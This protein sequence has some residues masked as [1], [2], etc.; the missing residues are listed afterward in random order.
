MKKSVFNI[1]TENFSRGEGSTITQ[2]FFKDMNTKWDFSDLDYNNPNDAPNLGLTVMG[3][4]LSTVIDC[5]V[6]KHA[7]DLTELSLEKLGFT[8]LAHHYFELTE[9]I[10]K[11]AMVFGRSREKVNG[12]YVVAAVFRGTSS[13]ADVISDIKAEP[14]G[15]ENAGKNS[16]RKL[17]AYLAVEGLT[18]EN[19][20]LFITGHS[21]G[22]AA[23]SLVAI[24]STD[25]AERD[26]IF[27]Y[28]FATPNYARNGLTGDGM[29]MFCFCSNEDIVPQVPVGPGLDKTGAVFLLDRLDMKLNDPEKY[30]R[31][32]RFYKYFRG[33]DFEEDHDFQPVEY[34]FKAPIRIPNN[35]PISRNHLPYTYM[36]L[37]MAEVPEA[38][39][40]SYIS[41]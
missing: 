38:I 18:K 13:V 30:K 29:K 6:G 16:V 10:N 36:S 15:F 14:H 9:M 25:L 12:K 19:T 2:W 20:I 27:C 33:R 40:E 8:D 26:S 5:T 22:A 17:K 3:L 23:A 37:I 34:T 35:N 32:E 31:F 7:W 4:V 24:H 39:A 1:S 21:Y 11:P 41:F 28:S